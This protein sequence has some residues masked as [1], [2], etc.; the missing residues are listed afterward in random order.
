MILMTQTSLSEHKKWLYDELDIAKKFGVLNNYLNIPNFVKENINPK[1][2]LRPYQ[3]EAFAR[4]FYYFNDYPEKEFPIH[5]LFN[6]ATGS[7]KTLIMAGLILYLYN[8]GYRNFLF[9]VNSTNIIEKTK[10]NFLNNLSN[11]FL[12]NNKLFFDNKEVIIKKVDNFEG[13]SNDDINI[14]FTTIQK[15]HTD[16]TIEK[17]NSLTFE[18]FK[19]KKI[20]LIA[21]EAHHGQVNTKQKK[22]VEKPNWENTVLKIFEKN[23]EN[24]LLEF[25]ATMDFSKKE[26]E[27]K[28]K[29]KLIYKYDLK[30]FRNDKYSKDVEILRTDADKKGRILIALLLN[31]YRQDV[32]SKYGLN[33]KPVILFKAQKTIAQSK[34]NKELFH[35]IIDE[36]SKKDIE[37]IKKKTNI[38]EITKLFNFYEKE[39]VN[40]DI[41]IQKFKNNFA[42]NK[43]LSVNEESEK[44]NYQLLLNSLEDNNNQIR[45]IFAVQKLNEGW[46]VLNLYDIVRVY[47]GQAGGGGYAGKVSPSTISEAQLIG[48]GARYNPFSIKDKDFEEFK[49]KFDDDLENDLRILEE[50]HFHSFNESRYIAELKTALVNE[51]LIDDK[52]EE[53]ELK[54]KDSF[55]KTFFYKKGKIYLNYRIENDYSNITS[56]NDLGVKDRDFKHEMF[57]LQGGVTQALTDEKYD[58][59]FIKKIPKTIVI[60]DIEKHVI[61]NALSKKEF[62]KFNNLKTKFPKIESINDFIENKEY[63]ADINIIFESTKENIDNLSNSDIFEGVLKVLDEIENKLKNNIVDYKGSSVFKA[64]TIAEVFTDKTLKIEKGSDKAKGQRD[65][66]KDKNWY[67]FNENYGTIEEKEL[68]KLMDRLIEEK[69]KKEYEEIYLIRNELHFCIY[70][71]EDGQAFSPDFVLFMKNKKGKDLTYQIFIEPKGK[72]LQEH[73]QWKEQFLLKIKEKFNSSDLMKFIET[74]KYKVIGVQFYNQEDENQFKEELLNSINP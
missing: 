1:F 39:N 20:V 41:L 54:L 25:T 68:V 74:S 14:C 13:V 37:I 65:F 3:E 21:D 29:D 62:F 43:C 47:E 69:F 7:G 17:E 40:I 53:K 36:L 49:R 63:L 30:S 55:K 33:V 31:Q 57:S 73:D 61:F 32:A 12:F 22:L 27:D 2:K 10:D 67:V 44:E 9:F 18:D 23:N 46:D 58:N 34:E 19:D 24:L 8:K 52:T 64:K 45:V 50:L 59:H 42:E 11:K 38:P 15:L 26:I 5:L 35:K 66:V 16:L 72:H 6:M 60:K 48:R 28:Y 70:N 51:G 4:F 71:F 56:L